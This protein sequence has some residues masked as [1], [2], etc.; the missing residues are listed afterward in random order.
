M[1]RDEKQVL[2]WDQITDRI[3]TKQSVLLR[4]KDQAIEHSNYLWPWEISG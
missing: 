4:D 3:L 1:V 2:L